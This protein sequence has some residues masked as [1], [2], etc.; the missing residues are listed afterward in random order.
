[1]APPTAAAAAVRRVFS[2]EL[3][4]IGAILVVAVVFGALLTSSLRGGG[5][6]APRPAVTTESIPRAV[7]DGTFKLVYLDLA[8]P[9]PVLGFCDGDCL[10]DPYGP[11]AKAT[12]EIHENFA[13]DH[14]YPLYQRIIVYRDGFFVSTDQHTTAYFGLYLASAIICGIAVVLTLIIAVSHSVT[15]AR[16]PTQF[17]AHEVSSHHPM[18]NLRRSVLAA[19]IFGGAS[20]IAMVTRGEAV[21]E[22]LTA[23]VFTNG[24]LVALGLFLEYNIGKFFAAHHGDAFDPRHEVHRSMQTGIWVTYGFLF[25]VVSFHS[26]MHIIAAYNY[27]I[28][29]PGLVEAYKDTVYYTA[30]DA[31]RSFTIAYAV[32]WWIYHVLPPLFQVGSVVEVLRLG[33]KG[34]GRATFADQIEKFTQTN[35]LRALL[36][37]AVMAL[38]AAAPTYMINRTLPTVCVEA[39][40]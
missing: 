38:V 31:A 18:Y 29:D 24:L 13:V 35:T 36:L 8:V 39:E 21:L 12:C 1:M 28:V 34:K 4:S 22:D 40:T 5:M 27:G 33:P 9:E 2:W 30:P 20:A 7:N 14:W 11:D 16:G 32:I 25:L 3:L 26:A 10:L 19:F 15:Q 6:L 23:E 37:V 17:R